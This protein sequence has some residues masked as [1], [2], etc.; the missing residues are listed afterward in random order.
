[1]NF[2]NQNWRPIKALNTNCWLVMR[3]A[4]V[5]PLSTNK[6]DFD[7]LTDGRAGKV[8]L[9]NN[10]L[11]HWKQLDGTNWSG[12]FAYK[13]ENSDPKKYRFSFWRMEIRLICFMTSHFNLCT[14][15]GSS[16]MVCSTVHLV[17][18]P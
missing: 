3:Q 4:A 15:A 6:L 14:G 17:F 11:V 13:A 12:A 8:Q 10:G 5:V 9:V 18:R 1:M 16:C 2:N 7:P